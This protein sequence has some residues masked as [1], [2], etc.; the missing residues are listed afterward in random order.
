MTKT[1]CDKCGREFREYEW[2]P[3]KNPC[4]YPTYLITVV[5]DISSPAR[6]VDLCPGC[7]QRFDNWLHNKGDVTPE[8]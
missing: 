6:K 4:Q 2:H 7:R 8:E 3:I 5:E 1:I